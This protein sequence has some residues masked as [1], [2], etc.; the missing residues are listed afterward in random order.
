[1]QREDSHPFLKIYLKLTACPQVN[2]QSLETLER[3]KT[4]LQ[5]L[6]KSKEPSLSLLAKCK[7]L[8]LTAP[9]EGLEDDNVFGELR[10]LLLR[11][12]VQREMRKGG[13]M[14][15]PE[16]DPENKAP[17]MT[18]EDAYMLEV[19]SR[20][21]FSFLVQVL[22]RQVGVYEA[23]E[24]RSGVA[25]EK[26]V[27]GSKLAAQAREILG[28]IL[29]A[30]LY[31]PPIQ[32]DLRTRVVKALLVSSQTIRKGSHGAHWTKNLLRVPFVNEVEFLK[33]DITLVS[34]LTNL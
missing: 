13:D 14:K 8:N 1:M 18:E 33:Q 16:H 6:E 12:T 7:R 29:T 26:L 3:T 28:D 5:V 31:S 19:V 4:L 25:H 17:A 20:L 22:D 24:I 21:Y 27:A 2:F 30:L 34:V 9:L 10:N 32:R 11:E 15:V 23:H